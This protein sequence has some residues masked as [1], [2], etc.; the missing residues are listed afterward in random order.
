MFEKIQFSRCPLQSLLAAILTLKI[1]YTHTA[2]YFSPFSGDFE[3][4]CDCLEK[5]RSIPSTRHSPGGRNLVFPYFFSI[6]VCLSNTTILYTYRHGTTSNVRPI[7]S[8]QSLYVV[9][10]KVKHQ[11]GPSCCNIS[12]AIFHLLR[13]S[14]F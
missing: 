8:L 3:V 10:L 6:S 9:R 4:A 13:V 7:Y 2:A 14:Y 11:K 5:I 1:F 12:R